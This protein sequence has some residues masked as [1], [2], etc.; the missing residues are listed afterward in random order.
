LYSAPPLEQGPLA[1]IGRLLG[2]PVA[3]AEELGGGRN[4][5]VF[6]VEVADGYPVAVKVYARPER[7]R[8]EYRALGF[9]WEKGIRA[10]PRPLAADPDS[11]CAAYQFIPGEKILTGE[12]SGEDIDAAVAFLVSL[13]QLAQ[14]P[15]SRALPAASEACPALGEIAGNIEQRLGRFSGLP[16]QEGAQR[17]LRRFL[18]EEFAPALALACRTV[19]PRAGNQWTAP[20][21]E[22]L[23]TLSPS[24]F[25]FHNALRQTD[26]TLVFLD[27]E[28]FGW[29]DPAKMAADFLL[30]PHES[31]AIDPNLRQRFLDHLLSRFDPGKGWL[32]ERVRLALPLYGLKWCIILLNE[33]LPD[34]L[35]RRRFA[36]AWAPAEENLQLAQLEKARAMLQLSQQALT[37]IL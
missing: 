10:V 31:M 30:H 4:S 16:D 24:D 17:P 3:T 32:E 20:L 28:H 34:A 6:R 8:T 11:G 22:P 14:C 13:R 21:A 7:L 29:D 33:F 37:Q 5:R 15:D 23:K 25:G 9:L 19:A 12:V 2:Q 35:A 26:G 1:L 18:A 27:F 36:G